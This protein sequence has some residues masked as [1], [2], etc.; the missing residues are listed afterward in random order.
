MTEQGRWRATAADRK[1]RGMTRRH[2]LAGVSLVQLAAGLVGLPIGIRKRMPSDPVGMH[3]NLSADHL[4]R[5][6]IVLGTARSAPGVMLATQAVATAALLGG[7]S[8]AARRTL[9]VLGCIMTFGYLIERQP[10]LLPG[11]FDPVETVAYQV[12]LVGAVLMA[13]FGLHEAALE[14]ADATR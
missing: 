12:G 2:A 14:E 9:G 4:V 3:L 11:Q 6:Q 1:G 13:W 10:A 7:P 8:A 5:D